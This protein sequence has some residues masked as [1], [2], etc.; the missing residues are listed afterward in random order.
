MRFAA[1][2]AALLALVAACDPCSGVVACRDGPHLTLEGSVIS[3]FSGQPQEGVRIDVVRTGG[4][5][6]A[7]ESVSTLTDR[8]GHWA[9]S[10]EAQEGGTATVAIGVRSPNFG[11][12]RVPD[13]QFA[14]TEL[15]GDGQI[16]PPWVVDPYFPYAAELYYRGPAD[17]RVANAIVEF[18]RRTGLQFYL[19][20]GSTPSAYSASTDGTG[21]VV[22]FDVNAH[23]PTLGT[24]TGDVVAH[25]PAPFA[26]DTVRGV[27]LASTYRLGVATKILR[28]GVGPSLLYVGEIHERR[29]DKPA[30]GVRVT[31][32]RSGGVA[33]EPT[34]FTTVTDAGGRFLFPLRPLGEGSLTGELDLVPQLGSAVTMKNLVLRPHRDDGTGFYG[35]WNVGP[36]LPWVGLVQ[37]GGR[38]VA[39]VEAEFHRTGGVQVTPSDYVTRS[40]GDGYIFL[41]PQP[42]GL[43]VVEADVIIHSP[44]PYPEMRAHITLRT[45]END[46]DGGVAMQF[47]LD[48]RAVITPASRSPASRP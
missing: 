20:D 5:R 39:G 29:N 32:R 31:F 45:V 26:P 28:L 48:S 40:N 7:A 37:I 2:A 47:N 44:P 43:G 4:V 18:V 42:E 33:S 38:G 22:L 35:V 3:H 17:V 36:A 13:L 16:L 27:T 34:T 9:V 23:A 12:Y 10:V 6:L 8:D 41:N 25:L 19:S 15:R 21:R 14:T 11:S 30:P 24:V 46:T 1:A